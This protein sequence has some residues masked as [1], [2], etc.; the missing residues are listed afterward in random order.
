MYNNHRVT[1]TFMVNL[2]KDDYSI[3]WM[4]NNLVGSVSQQ[5]RRNYYKIGGE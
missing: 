3:C 5:A 2:I 4:M 1:L